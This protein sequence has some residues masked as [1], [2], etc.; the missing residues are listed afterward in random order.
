M[1]SREIKSRYSCRRKRDYMTFFAV[2]MFLLCIV[3]EVY[4][5]FVV[6]LQLKQPQ[7]LHQE[8]NRQHL[9]LAQ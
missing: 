8:G 6:P 1:P 3:L 4:L 9:W 5:V 7:L 2:F